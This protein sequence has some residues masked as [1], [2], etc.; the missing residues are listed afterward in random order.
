MS[1]KFHK[2]CFFHAKYM[3]EKTQKNNVFDGLEKTPNFTYITYKLAKSNLGNLCLQFKSAPF[4]SMLSP[5]CKLYMSSKFHK[6]FASPIR[7]KRPPSRWDLEVQVRVGWISAVV[8]KW[9]SVVE[10]KVKGRPVKSDWQ[11]V[12]NKPK[13][14]GYDPESTKRGGPQSLEHGW[15]EVEQEIVSLGSPWWLEQGCWNVRAMKL[16]S[17]VVAGDHHGGKI[18]QGILQAGAILPGQCVQLQ[19]STVHRVWVSTEKKSAW[20][21]SYGAG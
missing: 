3:K 19:R 16:P 6:L 15:V 11:S 8:Q 14:Y 10:E 4:I 5:T 21:R 17:V 20:S 9:W 2:M 18:E 12:P 13:E 7:K 1:L